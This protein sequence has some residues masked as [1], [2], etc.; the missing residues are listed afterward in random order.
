[1]SKPSEAA[2]IAAWQAYERTMWEPG[3]GKDDPARSR[4]MRAAIEAAAKVDKVSWEA[5]P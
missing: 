3:V 1:M 5:R 2:I 4:C